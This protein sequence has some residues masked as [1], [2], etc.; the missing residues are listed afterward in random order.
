[1]KIFS[2]HD[3]K[4]EAYLPPIFFRTKG[5]AVRAFDKTCQDPQSQFHEY[6]SDFTLVELGLW[7]ETTAN[8]QLHQSP[9]ILHNASEFVKQNQALS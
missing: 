3:C 4:T 7:D 6:A 5:E 9:I 8:F 2:V 1:M